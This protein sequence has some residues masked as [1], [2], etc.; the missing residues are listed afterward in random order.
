MLWDWWLSTLSTKSLEFHPWKRS[1]ANTTPL[2]RKV[3]KKTKKKTKTTRPRF[4]PVFRHFIYVL[5][6]SVCRTTVVLYISIPLGSRWFVYLLFVFRAPIPD[7][8]EP[9]RIELVF[10]EFVFSLDPFGR[11]KPSRLEARRWG[12][13]MGRMR[14][15]NARQKAPKE[16]RC[17]RGARKGTQTV[18][19]LKFLFEQMV[20]TF[21]LAGKIHKFTQN[22]LQY[23]GVWTADCRLIIERDYRMWFIVEFGAGR[24]YRWYLQLCF[25]LKLIFRAT[26]SWKQRHTASFPTTR[27]IKKTSASTLITTRALRLPCCRRSWSPV[28]TTLA[29]LD[30][31]C[32]TAINSID[33]LCNL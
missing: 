6:L 30:T 31:A 15:S 24:I 8:E 3:R 17:H 10:D 27:S 16:E 28:R 29:C 9:K 19:E 11:Q 7:H 25:S 20:P 4:Q 1:L 23:N 2:P 5:N 13:E 32:F 14:H 12:R 26:M 22:V 21:F 18:R 33:C